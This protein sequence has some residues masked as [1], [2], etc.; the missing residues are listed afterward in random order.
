[1]LNKQGFDIWANKYDQSVKV[2][3]D[4]SL[5]PFAGYKK[6]IN[7]IYNE[8]M[9]KKHALVLDIGI[10]TAILSHRLYDNGHSI[11]GLDFS[12]KMIEI[13]Q[14][15]MPK[16]NVLECDF[17]AG[18]PKEIKEKK[19][20][21][22]VSTYALHHLNDDEKLTFIKELL[23][24]ITDNGKIF[25]GDIAFQNRDNLEDCRKESI[26]YWDDDEFYFVYDEFVVMLQTICTCEFHPISHCGGILILTK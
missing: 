1:M 19:Y 18:L 17:S 5:Y 20:D 26:T 3:E 23:P 9:Q 11:D 25:I 22:I 12:A 24:L 21:F 6:V 13:A 4:Q 8:I 7:T 2:S 16:A 10:G 15:K 14:A